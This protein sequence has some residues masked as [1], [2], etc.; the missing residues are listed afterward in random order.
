MGWKTLARDIEA[1]NREIDAYNRRVERDA[2]KRHRELA[3]QEERDRK[4]A[5]K[6]AGRREAERQVKLFEGYL[7]LLVSVH[8]DCGQ[9]LDLP[10]IVNGPPP[11]QPAPSN[12]SEATARA[13]LETYQPSLWAKLFG[14]VP[15]RRAELE[16]AISKGAAQDRQQNEASQAA[17]VAALARWR[18]QVALAKRL[19]DADATAYAEALG[20]TEA[21]EE[22]KRFETRVEVVSAEPEVISLQCSL[23]DPELVPTEIVSVSAAGKLTAKAMPAGRYWALYQDHVC[24]CALRAAREALALLPV[25]RVIVNVCTLKLDSSTG[26]HRPS[27]LLAV[28][29]TREGVSQLNV[30]AIDPSDALKNFPHRMK[31]KKSAGFDEVDAMTPDEQWVSA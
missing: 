25:S 9:P 12:R 21:F 29:Y 1:A 23:E 7:E 5:E 19:L 30:D 13:A 20:R 2:V 24:S 15:G 18:E 22:L 26:H 3:R 17:Y 4:L 16:R 8:K 27:T 28:Q 31:F 11:A 14:L 6:E 10:G